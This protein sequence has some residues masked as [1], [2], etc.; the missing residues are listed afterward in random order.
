MSQA[1]LARLPSRDGARNALHWRAMEQVLEATPAHVTHPRTP[2]YFTAT[3]M[4]A[5][6]WFARLRWARVVVDLGL[7]V[8]AW[9][10]PRADYP[11]AE[12]RWLLVASSVLGLYVASTLTRAGRVPAWLATCDL[13]FQPV[14]LTGLLELTGGPFNPF[15]V[16]YVVPVA[17][18]TLM[19]NVTSGAAVAL[20]GAAGYALLAY[21]HVTEVDE[22]H[23]S[24]TDFPTHLYT[25][26]VTISLTAELA[27]YFVVQASN[28]LARR[29]RQ[30]EEMR[31]RAS[32]ADRLVSLTTLAAGAAHELSTPLGTIALAARELERT[33][34]DRGTVPDLADDARLIRAEVERC[35][36]ILDQ[37]SGRAGGS[38]ADDPEPFAIA[39]LFADV[40]ARVPRDMVG[41]VAMEPGDAGT[42]VVLPR[43]GLT[44][45]V[46]TLVVNA[47]EASGDTDPIDVR[48]TLEDD[49]LT[50]AV[51]DAGHGMPPEV[52]SRAG[53]PFYTTKPPGKGLGLGLFLARVYAERVGGSLSLESGSGTTATLT[54][55]RR[56]Q[57]S[58][59]PA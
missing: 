53:E 26:W 49:M 19:V 28:A 55:P 21:W 31:E 29:E 16:V 33:A 25:M 5:V 24:L 44:Q 27:A 18:A 52:L 39:D 22:G 2:W 10:V 48:A 34:L 42:T 11:L 3:S 38:M 7:A 14:L 12:I 17:L 40:R 13:V 32:R 4:A 50:I 59:V 51:R 47:L 57:G 1:A 6:P 37:M 41:R 54:V 9:L 36:A 56:F 20:C 45:A 43:R 58:D 35:R 15:A 8:A 30:I 23:H 46:V